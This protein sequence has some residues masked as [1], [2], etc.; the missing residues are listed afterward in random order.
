LILLIKGPVHG[1]NCVK[2]RIVKLYFLVL[3]WTSFLMYFVCCTFFEIATIFEI[4]YSKVAVILLRIDFFKT[5]FEKLQFI[6]KTGFLPAAFRLP[7]FACSLM[8][9]DTD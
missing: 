5:Y 7:A 9:Q 8:F 4:F 3:F 2:M 1:E 6:D